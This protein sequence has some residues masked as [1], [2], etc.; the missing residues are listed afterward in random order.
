MWNSVVTAIWQAL[1][2]HS[3]AA[4][5]FNFRGVGNS[6]G[7]YGKGI[8][9]REDAKAALDFVLST[10]GI[11]SKKIGLAG[12]SFG[13]M[14]A[15]PVALQDERVSRLALVSAPLLDSNWE[16]LKRY[17]KPKLYLVGD[18]DQMIPLERFRQQIKDIPDPG[19]YQIISGADHFLGGYEEEVAQR[20]SRFFTAGFS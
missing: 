8:A 7:S 11:D 3:I 13:A 19:Q 20:V 15:L 9:E 17:R 6:E 5:R 1:F 16:Q 18:V 10:P 14:V 4:F 2:R 12:Y